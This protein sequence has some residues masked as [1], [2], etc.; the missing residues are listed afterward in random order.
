MA[1]GRGC[2]A[3]GMFAATLKQVAIDAN[4]C[5]AHGEGG[6]ARGFDFTLVVWCVLGSEKLSLQDLTQF[7]ARVQGSI[8]HVVWRPALCVPVPTSAGTC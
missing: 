2:F 7:G 1:S 3:G 8:A 5:G 6:I 4:G